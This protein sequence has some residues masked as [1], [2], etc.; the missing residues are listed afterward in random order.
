MASLGVRLHYG[1]NELF[2]TC[3]TLTRGSMSKASASF[4]VSE[5]V[6]AG[7]NVVALGALLLLRD[8]R[9]QARRAID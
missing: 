4:N 2:D 5:D 6:F 8:E 3:W 9:A 1:Y 7:L